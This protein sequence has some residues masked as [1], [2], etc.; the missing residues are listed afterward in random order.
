MAH[1]YWLYKISTVK[2]S[3]LVSSFAPIPMDW[4]FLFFRVPFRV[5][6]ILG[7]NLVIP[8]NVSYPDILAV[9]QE[10]HIIIQNKVTQSQ[11]I[12]YLP[13]RISPQS[14]IA[15]IWHRD[16]ALSLSLPWHKANLMLIRQ[17]QKLLYYLR[18]ILKEHDKQIVPFDSLFSPLPDL[19]CLIKICIMIHP[20][21][22]I[23]QCC[24]WEWSLKSV[25]NIHLF[26]LELLSEIIM[27]IF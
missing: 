11:I 18:I 25:I 19:F 9:M 16:Q 5:P 26:E 4:A 12:D 27:G 6:L 20:E 8:E 21:R 22:Y 7:H 24:H 15:L 17:T 1:D 13:K 2:I 23:I 3:I 14:L 10:L